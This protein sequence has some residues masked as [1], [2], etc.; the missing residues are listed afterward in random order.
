MNTQMLEQVASQHISEVRQSAFRC[1]RP[2]ET[3]SGQRESIR[4]RAGW[5]LLNVGLRLTDPPA[6][7]QQARPHPASL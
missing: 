5:T 2:S 1:H 4:T 6:K 7:G 3:A